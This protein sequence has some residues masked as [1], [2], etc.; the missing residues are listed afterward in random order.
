MAKMAKFVYDG[1]EN[2]VKKDKMLVT[3]IFSFSINAFKRLISK[4]F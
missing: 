2:I 3:S 4:G 1:V